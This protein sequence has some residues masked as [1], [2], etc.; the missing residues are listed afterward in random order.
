MDLKE[1]LKEYAR[2][3]KLSRKPS[4]DEF[5]QALKVTLLGIGVLGAFAFA[6]KLLASL[7]QLTARGG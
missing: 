1:L 2:T 5:M 7:I 6:I 3:V 4:R